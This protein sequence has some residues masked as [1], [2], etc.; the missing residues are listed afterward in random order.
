MKFD[1]RR[2]RNEMVVVVGLGTR[3]LPEC[4]ILDVSAC[5]SVCTEC[6]SSSFGDQQLPLVRNE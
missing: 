1:S 5:L 2:L 6:V 3:E 4:F